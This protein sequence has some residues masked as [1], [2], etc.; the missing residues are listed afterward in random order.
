MMQPHKAGGHGPFSDADIQQ[1]MAET[2]YDYDTVCQ[3]IDRTNAKTKEDLYPQFYGGTGIEPQTMSATGGPV[4]ASTPPV[5]AA[6]SASAPATAA[7]TPA[8]TPSGNETPATESDTLPPEALEALRASMAPPE[9]QPTEN[10]EPAWQQ[11][12]RRPRY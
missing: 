11:R 4:P 9:Q 6:A 12:M 8:V 7:A 1:I 10:G 3:D 5:P 2:G